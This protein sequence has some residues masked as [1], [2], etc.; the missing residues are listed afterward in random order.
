MKKGILVVSFGTTYRETREK[1]IDRI[2]SCVKERFPGYIVYQ[3]FSSEKIRKILSA[4]DNEFVPGILDALDILQKQGITHLYVLPTHIIDG[5]ENNRLRQILQE[6]KEKFEELWMAPVLLDSKE[7]YRQVVQSIWD[8]LELK[9]EDMVLF[10]GHGT[11]HQADCSYQRLEET[12]KEVTGKKGYMA[13][14]E[15]SITIEQALK[16]IKQG[17]KPERIV[18][19]P[20]MLV[21]GEHANKDMAGEKDSFRAQLHKEGYQTK[22]VLKGLGEY[23]GIREIYIQHL[24]QVLWE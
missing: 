19:V 5:I 14:V 22:V 7:D 6:Q 23:K 11:S 3:A 9:E 1:N 13:T 24:K 10:M 20:F 4:R 8:E 21:A 2:V 16:Q 12:W 15:G 18:L 17:P